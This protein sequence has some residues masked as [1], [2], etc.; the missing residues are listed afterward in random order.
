VQPGGAQT[1]DV[2]TSPGVSV[3]V[4]TV[5]SDEKEGTTHGG[6]G[7][8]KADAGGRFSS[9]WTVKAGTPEGRATTF[10][11]VVKDGVR[12]DA[13]TSFLVSLHCSG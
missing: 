8:G 10:V 5:Y 12:G 3:V 4:D 2:E 13:S 6:L 9:T 7:S 1:A 11:R